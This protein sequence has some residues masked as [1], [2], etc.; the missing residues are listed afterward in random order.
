MSSHAGNLGAQDPRRSTVSSGAGS[1]GNRTP[2]R[3]TKITSRNG[4][5]NGKRPRARRKNQEGALWLTVTD[6]PNETGAKIGTK[7]NKQ[8]NHC[9]TGTRNELGNEV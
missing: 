3:R 1:D 2:G 8:N 7:N 4:M 6:R 5:G 9:T